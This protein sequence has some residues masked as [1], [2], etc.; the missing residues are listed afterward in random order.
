MVFNFVCENEYARLF[1]KRQSLNVIADFEIHFKQD[2]TCLRRCKEVSKELFDK[3]MLHLKDYMMKA[4][5]YTEIEYDYFNN[6]GSV[7]KKTATYQSCSSLLYLFHDNS[8]QFYNTYMN[9]LIKRQRQYLYV[10]HVKVTKVKWI[11]ISVLCSPKHDKQGKPIKFKPIVRM[12]APTRR[13]LNDPRYREK[14]NQ[15]F[16]RRHL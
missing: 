9:V 1:V 6:D 13:Q 7:A 3:L 4:K 2:M 14:L 10:P 11:G 16:P 5:L 15:R 12:I 8:H